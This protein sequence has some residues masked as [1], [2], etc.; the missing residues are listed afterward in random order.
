[1]K[2]D[3]HPELFDITAHCACGNTFATRSTARDIRMTLC[4]ACHPF[5]SGQ[6]KFIDTVG[7]IKKFETK[8]AKKK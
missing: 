4:S 5:F 8:Y 3:I 2:K 1:M 6:Q 7:R